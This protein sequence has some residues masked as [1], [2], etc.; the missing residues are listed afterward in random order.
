MRRPHPAVAEADTGTAALS[1]DL[2]RGQ[3]GSGGPELKG[4]GRPTPRMDAQIT[5]IRASVS[6]PGRE[7]PAPG[8]YRAPSD[9]AV[10]VS[11]ATC[12]TVNIARRLRSSH[13]IAAYPSGVTSVFMT[14][15][16]TP[17]QPLHPYPE[18]GA[19]QIPPNPENC[20]S[21]GFQEPLM[22]L[23]L[24]PVMV[25]SACPPGLGFAGAVPLGHRGTRFDCCTASHA[26]NTRRSIRRTVLSST[27][28]VSGDHPAFSE[29]RSVCHSGG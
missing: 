14:N 7:A 16:A 19:K 22:V 15:D 5:Q 25:T 11:N 18:A 24:V 27:T 8:G 26:L 28:G 1:P 23:P 6:R 29:N 13:P 9:R 3:E 2:R 21:R 4:S 12:V 20:E 17:R 10:T